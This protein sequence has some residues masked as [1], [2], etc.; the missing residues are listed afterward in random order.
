M[1]KFTDDQIAEIVRDYKE[2]KDPFKQVEILADLNQVSK[3]ELAQLLAAQGCEV[4]G[5]YLAINNAKRKKPE[6]PKPAPKKTGEKA[7]RHAELCR[8]LNEIYR[9]KNAD[10]G[11]SFH[12]TWEEEGFAMARIRLSDKLSR[13]KTLSRAGAQQVKD[14][15]IADT[16]LDLANYAIM[17][18]LE[19]QSDDKR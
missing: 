12:T 3:K 18:V 14:E 17:T 2:A 9:K 7:D 4:D 16:L 8:R 1:R 11:D 13:F 10:Y 19:M 6:A 5:R 15:S